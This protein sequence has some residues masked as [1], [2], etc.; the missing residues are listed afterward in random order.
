MNEINQE[1]TFDEVNKIAYVS[2]SLIAKNLL[3][4]L[5]SEYNQ[6]LLNIEDRANEIVESVRESIKSDSPIENLLQEYE[7]NTKEGTVLLCLGRLCFEFQ[8]KKRW[9]DYWRINFHLLI[10]K[11]ILVRIKE[12]LS[13]R[14]RGLFFL[15]ETYLIEKSLTKRSLRKH[16]KVY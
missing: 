1:L 5:K 10:G 12:F 13:M 3:D 8:I 7:L 6:R 2:E 16:I 4:Y 15:Q 14:H 11:N 9:T